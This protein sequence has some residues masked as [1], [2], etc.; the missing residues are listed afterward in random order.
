M[1]LVPRQSE[2]CAIKNG[3][4]NIRLHGLGQTASL[5]FGCC[6][7]GGTGLCLA[8]LPR[9]VEA[10]SCCITMTAALQCL[11]LCFINFSVYCPNRV[12]VQVLCSAC[13]PSERGSALV[14]ACGAASVR[15]AVCHCARPLS[16]R[17]PGSLLVTQPQNSSATRLADAGALCQLQKCWAAAVTATAA[18]Q[19]L[20]ASSAMHSHAALAAC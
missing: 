8:A 12:L 5:P 16:R 20:L 19:P 9:A 10:D 17:P 15:Q 2:M 13:L 7:K 3:A 14:Q 18:Q 1:R 4:D 11:S 6:S